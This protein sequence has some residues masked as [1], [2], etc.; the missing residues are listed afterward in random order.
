[1]STKG[2]MTIIITLNIFAVFAY[3][4][5]GQLPPDSKQSHATQ[6]N[7]AE[8]D[9]SVVA[10][11]VPNFVAIDGKSAAILPSGISRVFRVEQFENV[12]NPK[13]GLEY[14]YIDNR[15]GPQ[16]GDAL[17]RWVSFTYDLGDYVQL[18][19][20]CSSDFNQPTLAKKFW[21][22]VTDLLE[23]DD[24]IIR[25]AFVDDGFVS[26][27]PRQGN[28]EGELSGCEFLRLNIVSDAD[29]P[30]WRVTVKTWA[31]YLGRPN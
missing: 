16:D 15:F 5:W 1:M 23:S 12:E 13:K 14:R 8:R 24:S 4:E 30:W 27:V 25:E 28:R 11:F 18:S 29:K 31:A 3:R 22:D 7:L 19:V 6:T 26:D 10:E 20:Y 21:T 9:I 17:F 2:W